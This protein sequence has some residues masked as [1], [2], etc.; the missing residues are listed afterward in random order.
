M[1]KRAFLIPVFTLFIALALWCA[2]AWAGSAQPVSKD[3][4]TQANELRRAQKYDD[5]EKLYNQ[6]KAENPGSAKALEAQKQLIH[7]AIDK[8]NLT[9]ADTFFNQMVTEFAETAGLDEAV[10]VTGMDIQYTRWN[11]AKANNFHKYNIEHFPETKFGMMSNVEIIRSYLRDGNK[12]AD[13]EVQK[14]LDTYKDQPDQAM[15]IYQIARA[16]VG[17]NKIEK[18]QQL[19]DFA[20][21]NHSDHVY[22]KLAKVRYN[23]TNKD[24]DAADQAADS[25]IAASEKNEDAREG[26]RELADLYRD[27]KEYTRAAHFYKAEVTNWPDS[28]EP[29]TPYREAVYC[30]I[31][32]KDIQNADALIGQMQTD[33]AKDPKLARTNFD[34]GNYF[35]NTAKDTQSALKIHA[36]NAEHY[37]NVM[38]AMWSQAA[39]VWYYVRHNDT[40]KADA[41]YAKLL[42]NYKGQETLPKEIFQI[43]DIYR[44]EK[45]NYEKAVSLYKYQLENWPNYGEP[46][47][48]YR[49][50]ACTYIDMKDNENADLIIQ[51]MQTNRAKDTH[52]A[53][54]NFDI[55]NYYLNDAN[56]AENALKIHKY[57]AD[58]HS[59]IMEAMWSQAAL[60]WYYVRHDDQANADAE[61]AKLLNTF[62]KQDTLAK[63]VFQIGDVY[64]EKKKYDKAISL[65]KYQLENWPEYG[66]P[67][68][69]YR[70][71]ACTYV[72]MNDIKNADTVIS[73]I[74]EKFAK[75]SNLARTN[76]DIGNYFLNDA[77]DPENAL[78]VHAYN[79]DHCTNQL[80]SMWSQAAI[81]WYYVRAKDNT[82]A[83][84]AYAKLLDVFKDQKTLAKE[85]FQ[86]ADIY[87]EVGNTTKAREL[88]N[89][90]LKDW[91]ESEYVFDARKGLIKADFADDKDSD[92]LTALDTLIADYSEKSD[93][94]DAIFQFGEDYYVTAIAERNKTY[95]EL[96]R[97]GD[98]NL[99]NKNLLNNNKTKIGFENTIDIWSRVINNLPA[100]NATPQA[101]MFTG[102][103][104]LYLYQYETAL[105]Y[106]KNIVDNWMNYDYAWLAQERI[107]KIYPKLYEA[108]IISKSEVLS[109]VHEAQNVLLKKFPDCPVA[110]LVRK[111]VDY[112]REQ[113]SLQKMTSKEK[114][115]YYRK[116]AIEG[117]QK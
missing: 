19:Y 82:K 113:E 49:K 11:S 67:I 34:I 103:I 50:L 78:K 90:V 86:I 24:F 66:E 29:T 89:K 95:E 111:Q 102:E 72:D 53:R 18:G 62:K 8:N 32:A 1:R 21:K 25:L 47:D 22:G 46:T 92:A 43:G 36:Y 70:K 101:Y 80:E 28:A 57:N 56:D 6:V 38:E 55:A 44:D 5:A 9:Q 13:A 17:N 48:I 45:K 20:I 68:D 4:L 23:I 98:G 2:I 63:E 85:V 51:Q 115:E 3:I 65:Y 99:S 71:M 35:L 114:F 112:R 107:L 40:E 117:G 116:K 31:N 41:E 88:H 104:Y 100:S 15:G 37:P 10:Y 12:I 7:L 27:K 106:Y 74:Q 94:T 105:E 52:L 73:D 108:G 64:R 91:P 59:G 60:V 97:T 30:Y 96:V 84:E 16:Y 110:D 54:S 76:F 83:D 14:W 75:N 42:S 26:I 79:A 61:Y 77:N 109:Q 69:I 87:T 58:N 39:V 33:L 81:V 93:I